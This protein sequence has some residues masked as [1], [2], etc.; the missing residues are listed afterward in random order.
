MSER[1]RRGQETGNQIKP[2]VGHVVP[3]GRDRA[4]AICRGIYS[5]KEASWV[6]K[7][8]GQR[9]GKGQR[10]KVFVISA[11]GV[12]HFLKILQHMSHGRKLP[13]CM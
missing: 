4:T 10:Q 6:T 7:C 12:F 5:R 3:V 1:G 2:L 11:L 8:S 9:E 13:R